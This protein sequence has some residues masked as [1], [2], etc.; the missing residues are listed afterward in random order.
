M[1]SDAHA[2]FLATAYLQ[3]VNPA[4]DPQTIGRALLIENARSLFARYEDRHG[5]A[6]D[7]A[8]QAGA[9]LYRPW[10]GNIDP[11]NLNKQAACADYQCCEHGVEWTGS[12]SAARLAE[13]IAATGGERHDWAEI[14]PW[15]IDCHPED[16]APPPAVEIIIDPRGQFGMFVTPGDG[17]QLDLGLRG[18]IH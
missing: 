9:Y 12:A 13:L 3:F 14:Y 8:E 4:A 5:C 16:E 10:R 15:G 6:A 2:D 17:L 7:G 11:E 1:I 18:T